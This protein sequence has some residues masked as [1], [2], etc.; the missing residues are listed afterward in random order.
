MYTT[1]PKCQHVRQP[2]DD[3]PPELCPRCGLVFSKW[4]KSLAYDPVFIEPNH[5]S[6]LPAQLKSTLSGFF[7]TSRPDIAKGEFFLYLGIWIV[8]LAW[9]IDFI[10]MDFRTNEIGHSWFH[11][12]DLVFHEA[13]HMLFIPFG[14]TMM[15]FGGSLLQVLVPLFLMFAFL[16]YNKDAF[17]A[18]IGLWWVGQSLM[19]LAPYIGDA[20]ALVLPLLGGGT[21]ADG[22]MRHDWA[23][24]LRPRGLL[25]YDT[26]I[27]FWV[28]LIG[29]GIILLALFWG[30]TML[31]IY[32]RE[33]VD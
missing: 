24:L 7:L 22:P 15:I 31:R 16:I 21:G 26:Q 28:D 23:N 11:N 30:L 13:G 17:A 5:T 14:D 29:S 32:Y 1:C 33:M 8:F 9:G 27:A 19:D 2:E 10:R 20:R 25:E 18:S 4:L 12:V 3:A 6:K